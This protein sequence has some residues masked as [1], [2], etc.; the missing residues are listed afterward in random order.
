MVKPPLEPEDKPTPEQFAQVAWRLVCELAE[1]D[2][3]VAARLRREGL[4]IP[5]FRRSVA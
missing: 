4:F 5:A 3:R 2:P 1:T